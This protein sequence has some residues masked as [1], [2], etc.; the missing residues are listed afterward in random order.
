ME[1]QKK[2]ECHIIGRKFGNAKVI[3]LALHLKNNYNTCKAVNNTH[4]RLSE[5]FPP[6]QKTPSKSQKALN[7][8]V[9]NPR[10]TAPWGLGR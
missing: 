2:Q 3:I 5:T 1:I 6:E 10:V 7:T 9:L 8:E 4:I